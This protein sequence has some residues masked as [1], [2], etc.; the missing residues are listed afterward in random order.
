MFF[1]PFFFLSTLS[2]NP[3]NIPTTK[4]L[5]VTFLILRWFP[6]WFIWSLYSPPVPSPF[7]SEVVC[8]WVV[9]FYLV[10]SK[11]DPTSFSQPCIATF[12]FCLHWPSA[13]QEGFWDCNSECPGLLQNLSPTPLLVWKCKEVKSSA[14]W[15]SY[16]SACHSR[17]Y[18]VRRLQKYVC[19]FLQFLLL[20]EHTLIKTFFFCPKELAT[21]STSAL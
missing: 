2:K 16:S 17:I 12:L 15:Q 11:S 8:W 21:E 5:P 6:L 3:P 1:L 4:K 18:V 14:L 7:V 13:W 9:L 10:P 19:R 20:A